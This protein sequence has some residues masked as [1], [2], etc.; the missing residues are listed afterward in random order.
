MSLLGSDSIGASGLASTTI[1]GLITLEHTYLVMGAVPV[2]VI[3]ATDVVAVITL[4]SRAFALFYALQC[5]VAVLVARHNGD[6]GKEKWF[7][8]LTLIAFAVAVLSIPA[9][10]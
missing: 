3:W 9:S 10:G 5:V 7:G 2:C 4:A 8:F 1:Q 6:R